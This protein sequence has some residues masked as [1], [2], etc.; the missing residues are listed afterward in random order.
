MIL[1]EILSPFKDILLNYRNPINYNSPELLFQPT[2]NYYMRLLEQK[3]EPPNLRFWIN[4][5]R[6]DID[7]LDSI[8]KTKV[9][10]IAD[11]KIAEF[12]FKVLH[13]ILSCRKYLSMWKINV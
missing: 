11:I 3:F 4:Y 7:N 12:N 9:V 6:N 8:F 5:L 2:K 10:D 1:K 13:N